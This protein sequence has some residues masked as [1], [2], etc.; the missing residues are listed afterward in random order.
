MTTEDLMWLAGLL[1]GEGSFL[2]GPPSHPRQP[3]IAIDMTDLDVIQ[4]AA[5]L[6]EV[7]YIQRIKKK[8]P[9]WKPSFSVRKR[10]LAA[11]ELMKVLRPLMGKRR[12]EQ[13]D[14]AIASYERLAGPRTDPS[15]PKLTETDVREI[16]A[17]FAIHEG[18]ER[19][20]QGTYTALEEKYGVSKKTLQRIRE[21]RIWKHVA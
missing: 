10:G 19:L 14:R 3:A 15:A 13:I 5:N 12:Q 11:L 9:K 16:K 7:N 21:G 8:N 1:E 2:A 20:P 4:K 17:T 18:A 6:L